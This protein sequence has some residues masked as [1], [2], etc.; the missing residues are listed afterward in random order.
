MERRV[1]RPRFGSWNIE[2]FLPRIQVPVLVVQGAD[3]PYGT[4]RQVDAIEAGSAGP[5]ERLVLSQC[6]HAPHR[7]Q[8]ERT[9][10]GATDFLVRSGLA[11][12][13]RETMRLLGWPPMERLTKADIRRAL[14]ALAAA[15]P[16]DA[17]AAELWV[18][19]G[20][21]MVLLYEA[22]ETTKDVDAFTIDTAG[23]PALRERRPRRRFPARSAGGLAERW[24]EG[25][26]KGWLPGELLFSHPRL[27]RPV[28]GG[29]STAGHEA[30]RLARRP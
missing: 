28:R 6:A 21:A 11:P 19:G 7:E 2:E 20:A 24:R 22:R 14:E 30:Q 26:L 4:L 13:A 5:V 12:W 27:R 10:E 17:A 1:A 16:P 15:L 29:S 3:D 9:L 25:Y 23:A 18:V 8:P